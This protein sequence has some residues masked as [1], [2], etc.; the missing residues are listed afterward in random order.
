MKRNVKIDVDVKRN[1]G[2]VF[3]NHERT[4]LVK[5]GSVYK[6]AKN[7][8]ERTNPPI[9]RFRLPW[10]WTNF[11]NGHYAFP[12]DV[13]DRRSFDTLDDGQRFIN[14]LNDLHGCRLPYPELGVDFR[15]WLQIGMI[16][17]T[18]N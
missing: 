15:E 16:P 5:E 9:P 17:F 14:L 6:W 7:R 12:D 8:K 4:W 13:H 3:Q 11:E 1:Y 10:K 18:S 2:D